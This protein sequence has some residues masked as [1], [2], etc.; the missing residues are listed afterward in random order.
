[1]GATTVWERWNSLLPDGTPNPEGMNS[2]N[3]YAYGSVMEFVYRRVAGIE[4]T[5]VGFQSVRIAPV[6]VEGL[7]EVRG[8]YNSIHGKITA[9]Y[10]KKENK[11]T[12]FAHVPPSVQAEIVLPDEGVV[13][14]GNG[15][16]SFER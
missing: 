10:A 8:E 14:T 7:N 5:G 16:F 15:D 4:A 1:M 9:G 6:P 3:H 2:Y 11:V 13:A 12:Y